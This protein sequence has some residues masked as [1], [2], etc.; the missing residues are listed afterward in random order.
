MGPVNRYAPPVAVMALIFGLSATPDLNSGLGAWD[1]WLRKAAHVTIFAALWL[2]LMRATDWRRPLLATAITLLYAI[3]DEYHQ[4]FVGGRHG[5]PV[6]VGID[7]AGV[8]LAAL[9]WAMTTRRRGRPGPPWP[10][11]PL[12]AAGSTASRAP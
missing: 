11:P 12:R 1:L 2:T 6:D 7:A 4:T 10:M 8:G 3:S 5:S 9:A